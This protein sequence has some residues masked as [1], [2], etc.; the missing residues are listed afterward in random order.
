M[1]MDLITYA[2]VVSV[3]LV[4]G[5]RAIFEKPNRVEI[6]FLSPRR[7]APDQHAE[8]SSVDD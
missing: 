8:S 5:L 3:F 6:P 1:L 4:T 7:N 2:S